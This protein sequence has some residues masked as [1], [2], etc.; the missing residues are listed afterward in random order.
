MSPLLGKLFICQKK[1][2]Q[3]SYQTSLGSPLLNLPSGGGFRP[4][5]AR[6][7]VH[8]LDRG[9]PGPAQP[10]RGPACCSHS[11][12][13]RLRG[14]GEAEVAGRPTVF[15][16]VMLYHCFKNH[17]QHLKLTEHCKLI[18]LQKKNHAQSHLLF[19]ICIPF[20]F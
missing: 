3:S 4:S 10:A 5:C 12:G 16:V 6:A 15:I 8:L 7:M 13:G 9:C 14:E 17:A 1:V 2:L 20:L 19:I 18:I 11:R